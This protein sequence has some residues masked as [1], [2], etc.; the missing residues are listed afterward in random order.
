MPAIFISHSS[1][2]RKASDDVKSALARLGF[3]RVFLD[4]DKETGLGIGENWEKRLYEEL[5]RCHCVLLVLTPA[6]LASKWCFAELTQARALGKVI[7]PV[8]CEPLGEKLVLPE[9]QAVDLIDWNA[10]ALGRIEQRL[11]A[12]SSELA[13][14]FTLDPDRPPYPGI[15]AF[16]TADAAIYFGRDEESRA[17]IERLDAR[18]TQGGARF[19]VIIG[20]SGSGKSSL[21]KAGVLPQLARRRGQWVVLPDIRPEKAPMEALA[22]ALAQHGGK[23]E[24]WR[25]WDERLRGPDA[26]AAIE[27]LTQDARVGDA[28]NATV[29]LPIDQFEEVFTTTDAEQRA[30]FLGLLAAVFARDLPFMVVATGRSDVLEGLID[31]SELV[32]RYETYPLPAMPLDRVPRL[33]EGPAA[34]AGTNIE[35]GLPERIVRDVESA[36]ALPLL[37]HTLSLL[38]Q[39]SAEA[40]KLALAAYDAL[41]DPERGLNPIQ[42]SVR[43]AADEAIARTRPNQ[44]ESAALRD[45]FIPH[46]VRVRL[47]DG[48]RVRQPARRSDLSQESLRLIAALVEARLLSTRADGGETLVEVTHEALFKAWPALDQWLTEEQAF[49]TDLERIRDAHEN[50][51]RAADDQKSGELLYGLLLSRAREWLLKY[52]QRFLGRDLEPLRAFIAKSAEVADVERERQRRKDRRIRHGAIAAAVVFA[53]AA[54]FSGWEYFK[55]VKAEQDA[56]EAW[57]QAEAQRDRAEAQRRQAQITQSRFMADVAQD[58]F[59]AGDFGTA[60]ALAHEALPVRRGNQPLRPY[61]ADAESVLYQAVTPLRERRVLKAPGLLSAAFS[62]DGKQIVTTS[63]DKTARVW[64]TASGTGALLL[65]GHTGLV[66]NAAFSPDGRRIATASEDGSVRLW[67]AA[68]GKEL[69]KLRG[70]EAGVARTVFSADGSRI[71]TASGDKTARIWDSMT[72]AA[73]AVLT[74]HTDSISS[75]IFSPDRQRIVTASSD[76]SARIWDATNGAELGVLKHERGVS[77]AAFSPDGNR[78][79]TAAQDGL[80]GLW[81][82]VTGAH[83]G[84][85]RGHASAVNHAEFSPDGNEVITASDDKTARIWSVTKSEAPQ[86]ARAVAEHQGRVL[87][88]TFAPGGHAFVTSSDDRTARIFH[89]VTGHLITHLR[90]HGGTVWSAAFSPDAKRV[91]TVAEDDAIRIWDATAGGQILPLEGHGTGV[92][93]AQFSPDG[94]RIVTLDHDGVLMMWD[95]ASGQQMQVPGGTARPVRAAAF[96]PKGDRI[97]IAFD[98]DTAQIRDAATGRE[99]AAVAGRIRNA[100]F[101][102]DGQRIVGGSDDRNARVWNAATGAELLAF[103]AGLTRAASFSLDGRRIVTASDDPTGPRVWDAATGAELLALRGHTGEINTVAFSPDGQKIVTASNDRTARIWDANTGAEFLILSTPDGSIFTAAFSPDGNRVV[104]A[105]NDNTGRIWDA[106]T[107]EEVGVL[108]G[109]PHKID[110]VSAAYAPDGRRIVTASADGKARVWPAFATTQDLLAYAGEIMPR[111]LTPEQR[112]EFFLD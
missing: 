29:L 110:F 11:R 40:R 67:D 68:S 102:P 18:R 33:I 19:L 22:K 36:D 4:F 38:Y 56:R 111:Q 43:L 8:L 16:E 91:V 85:L 108:R 76:G 88:A 95:A 71:A 12:V 86:E 79:V 65:Q 10:D 93:S 78:I 72:G 44:R 3:E 107:G 87:H 17:V 104:T 64:D 13:R 100:A 75:A 97:V 28:R 42:N 51:A 20:A 99:V 49:L 69:A 59:T 96:S 52:P 83:I 24:A 50:W 101:S 92:T 15:H 106:V 6:W 46:L 90:P 26:I 7:L 60:V 74:G 53:A 31:S 34:V 57:A 1:K 23:P 80:A 37:A 9:I 39:R 77:S 41:G 82:A 2:D 27:T 103:P 30:A 55:A 5:T 14:G 66:S 32:Q 94:Q 89:T 45:A 109:R 63:N 48:K 47:D 54:L 70:H 62:P 25:A 112:K 21:L 61:V 58:H 35:K 81:D 105:S 98:D 84:W 73:V